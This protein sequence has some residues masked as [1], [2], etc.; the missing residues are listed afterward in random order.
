MLTLGETKTAE[1]FVRLGK[2]KSV[3]YRLDKNKD[4]LNDSAVA[5]LKSA[6]K[7]MA[8]FTFFADYSTAV[9][10][11]EAE[12]RGRASAAAATPVK[13]GKSGSM[14]TV[15]MMYRQVCQQ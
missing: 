14:N 11:E 5:A 3:F 9:D 7:T 8:I 15:S 2:K 4:P 12:K 6:G 10:Q 1:N 13:K